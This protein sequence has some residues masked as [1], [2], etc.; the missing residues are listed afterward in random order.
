[1]VRYRQGWLV[2]AAI[3]SAVGA[4]SAWA[5]LPA[6]TAVGNTETFGTGSPTQVTVLRAPGTYTSSGS[7]S[8]QALSTIV[9]SPGGT[10]DP[11]LNGHPGLT[12]NSQMSWL[13][14]G[15]AQGET[16]TTASL[17]F[18][19]TVTGPTG[20][21]PLLYDAAA[22]L[23]TTQLYRN[24]SYGAQ[25]TV[26]VAPAGASSD[27]IDFTSTARG[28]GMDPSA[29]DPLVGASYL[30][31]GANPN[32]PMNTSGAPVDCD[33]AG[34]SQSIHLGGVTLFQTNLIYE[35]SIFAD[36]T[37][38][39]SDPSEGG[40]GSIAM[41][42][43]PIFAIDP[44]A[45]NA[46]D[47]TLTFSPGVVADQGFPSAPAGVPEPALWSVMI[48]GLGGVGAGLRRRRAATGT[49]DA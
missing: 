21:A 25:F 24:E 18:Y 13:G 6:S 43:D 10:A 33:V 47:Y 26:Q 11:G 19:F 5:D 7:G 46:A 34:C 39:L 49:A 41:M 12:I 16:D 14:G 48:L 8:A 15:A 27:L 45:P 22:S 32:G 40:S 3:F 20:S 30:L 44:N 2:L 36:T 35:V 9:V 1:M 29:P 17:K 37:I 28:D 4:T 38:K 23:A 31:V 42:V